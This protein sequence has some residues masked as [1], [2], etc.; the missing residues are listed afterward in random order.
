[1]PPS[2]PSRRYGDYISFA[3]DVRRIWQNCKVYNGHGTAVWHTADYMSKMFERL[4]AA[5]VMEFKDDKTALWSEAWARP[6]EP[7]CRISAG[8]CKAPDH[9]MVLCDHCDANFNIDCLKPPLKAIPKGIWHC[10]RC[11]KMDANRL[12][13]A[14]DEAIC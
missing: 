6:W 5:W 7:T 12:Q 14:S 11:R 10:P 4:F 8:K 1:P 2:L 13:S 9:K 3:R